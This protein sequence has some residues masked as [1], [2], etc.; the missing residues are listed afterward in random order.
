MNTS[1]SNT[2]GEKS[3]AVFI[4]KEDFEAMY[5]GQFLKFKKDEKID[6][7][8]GKFLVETGAPVK[9]VK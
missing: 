7:I 4:A 3:P 5:R 2:A 1:K 8:I 9:V 6:R